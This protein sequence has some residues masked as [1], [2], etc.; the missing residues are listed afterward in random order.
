[1]VEIPL[2][3]D[4][5][6]TLSTRRSNGSSCS[7]SVSSRTP[8]VSSRRPSVGDDMD[9]EVES[10]LVYRFADDHE[11]RA[12]FRLSTREKRSSAKV[13]EDDDDEEGGAG[14]DT[15]QAKKKLAGR[16]SKPRTPNKA[17]STA[18]PHGTTATPNKSSAK[19]AVGEGGRKRGGKSARGGRGGKKSAA[20]K[21]EEDAQD[22]M[23]FFENASQASRS[24]SSNASNS[25]VSLAPPNTTRISSL[26][27]PP[28]PL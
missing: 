23:K 2:V 24:N 17:T 12:S 1:M 16:P 6:S 7:S 25:S 11:R 18:K 13:V 20:T 10:D 15:K 21:Y 22:F 19:S 5:G 28:V 27:P 9:D 14:K 4:D 8:S 26:K 3:D